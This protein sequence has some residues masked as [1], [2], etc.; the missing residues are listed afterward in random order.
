MER[1]RILD[2]VVLILA[3]GAEV[4][5]FWLLPRWGVIDPTA[6]FLAG[7]LGAALIGALV[8]R[9]LGRRGA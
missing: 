4:L 7:G 9:A 8:V 1:T 6:G 3:L 2:F 5:A